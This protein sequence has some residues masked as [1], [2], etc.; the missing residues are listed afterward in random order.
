MAI[1]RAGPMDMTV[2]VADRASVPM[3]TGAILIFDGPPV[4]PGQILAVLRERVPRI[5]RLRKTLR[6]TPFGCGRPIWVDDPSFSVDRHF[7]R[8]DWPEAGTDP[9]L[10]GIAAELLCRPLDPDRPLWRAVLLTTP[11]RSA[12][13]LVMHHV[14]ADGLGGLA[15][16]S[17]L[18]DEWPGVTPQQTFPLPPPT[19]RQ[20]A[21]A[22]ARS[23]IRRLRSLPQD[24]RRDV[25]GMRELGLRP[26]RP[27][28]A[29][30]I[31]LVRPTSDRR[32][33][34]TVD[35]DLD[36]VVATAHR[37]DGTVNDVVLA[38]VTGA[39]VQILHARGERP[40]HLVVSV[41]V[42]GRPAADAADLGNNTGVR[43]ITVPAITDDEARLAEIVASTAAA[44]RAPVRAASA[45]PLGLAFRA[46]SRAGLFRLFIEHQRLIHTFETN[47][48]GPSSA[49][50]LAGHRITTLIPMTATPGNAGLTFAAL[51]YAG[52]MVISVI[53]D[54]DIVPELPALADTLNR[55]LA[56]LTAPAT[57]RR[58][59]E[60]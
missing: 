50:H 20:L 47:L 24:L 6:P 30:R 5:P 26:G 56:R 53:A 1:D 51:S 49:L 16:L 13:I 35:V 40:A 45:G 36:A 12:L 2:M 3:N 38:A 34:A 48:R 9:G 27:R 37:S 10:R 23:R 46:L 32:A 4:A 25:A 15:I 52:T 19:V 14:V 44:R 18:A 57:E 11:S 28:L 54:P 55:T 22:A 21:S 43:P 58:L 33:L 8:C 39:M 17:T 41:P 31:S 42:S 7:Q 29:E 60:R 59:D